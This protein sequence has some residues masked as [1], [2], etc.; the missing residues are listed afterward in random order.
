M[1]KMSVASEAPMANEIP[2]TDLAVARSIVRSRLRHHSDETIEIAI[3]LTTELLANAIEHGAGQPRIALHIDESQLIVRVHDED[4]TIDLAPLPLEPTRLRGRGL[5]MV[6]A[7]ASA[8]GVDRVWD[9]KAVWFLL[10]L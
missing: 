5:A 9:G 3:L 6:D 1:T 4:P 8:W 10:N 7:L 2:V